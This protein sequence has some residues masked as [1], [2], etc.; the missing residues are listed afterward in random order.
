MNSI[1]KNALSRIDWWMLGAVVV[2][3]GFG[4][5]IIHSL[6]WGEDDRFLRQLLFFGLG[7]GLMFGIQFLDIHFWRNASFFIYALVIIFLLG[8]IIFGEPV[9]GSR[10]W[11]FLWSFGIQPAEFAKLGT[12]FFLATAL[13]KFKFDL[14]RFSHL[15]LAAVIIGVPFVLIA[16]QPDFGA[17]FII[18]LSGAVMVLYTGLDKK[19][20]AV[21]IL[22][23]CALVLVGWFVLLRDYQKERILTFLNPQSD[24]L[25]SGYNV[26]Q[27][28][29][30]IGSGGLF[31]KG[32]GLGTQSQLDF[33]PEQETDFIFASLAEEL[34]FIGASAM[35]F[36]YLFF[37][38]RIYII[39]REGARPF[40]NFLMLGIF[41]MFFSQ[42][43]VNIGMNMG[44]F[45]VTGIT[46]PF[47]SYGGSSMIAS[48][49]AAGVAM[50][51]RA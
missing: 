51:A 27:S 48:F 23:G 28:M 35:I 13:E 38:W 21:L 12:V 41:I 24:P 10:G 16:S 17:A 3:S 42:G 11:I 4:L 43:A 14:V 2:L 19:K 5:A 26:I 49:W 47:V 40:S 34:G 46:L 20:L 37:L 50:N 44:I 33:L 36:A 29:V 32:L 15:A 25:E 31:G 45:P 18:F 22:S 39:L 6:T 9:K 30:A 7:L 8:L 1:F